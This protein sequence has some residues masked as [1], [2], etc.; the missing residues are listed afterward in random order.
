[1]H[2]HS[3]WFPQPQL[4]GPFQEPNRIQ[5][6]IYHRSTPESLAPSPKLSI[7]VPD[8]HPHFPS[9]QAPS[10]LKPI[11]PQ[12][13]LQH[14]EDLL[15]GGSLALKSRLIIIST[16]DPDKGIPRT[17]VCSQSRC[18]IRTPISIPWVDVLRPLVFLFLALCGSLTNCAS[19]YVLH[20]EDNR[21]IHKPPKLPSDYF[22][23]HAA[24]LVSTKQCSFKP[25]PSRTDELR[26]LS[27]C[28][29]WSP[30]EAALTRP[31]HCA[32]RNRVWDLLIPNS[33]W[34]QLFPI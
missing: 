15:S 29:E 17:K 10:I 11:N 33:K 12:C 21:T 31:G 8:S 26:S 14:S 25:E 1:V 5:T 22:L 13:A 2:L 28:G 4:H 16:V 27:A 18:P 23:K 30:R 3:N 9:P 32:E 6:F 20:D 7:D 19:Q 24:G 34:Q